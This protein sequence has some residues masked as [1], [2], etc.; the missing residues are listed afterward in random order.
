MTVPI[1]VRDVTYSTDALRGRIDDLTIALNHAMSAVVSS[2]S[3]ATDGPGR[4]VAAERTRTLTAEL[5]RIRHALVSVW[6]TVHTGEAGRAH[7][8]GDAVQLIAPYVMS[9]PLGVGYAV[10]T[11]HLWHALRPLADHSIDIMSGGNP[12]H[13]PVT[14][15]AL[16]AQSTSPPRSLQDRVDRIP[17]GDTHIRIERYAE[18]GSSRFEVY[19]SGT[20]FGGAHSDPWNA[21][22]NLDLV[23]TGS[24]PSLEAVKIAMTSAGITTQT[25]VVVTGHSQGGLLALAIGAAHQ[26]DVRAIITVGTPVGAVADVTD[27]PTVHV[28]HPEDPVPAFG[29]LIDP[30]SSTWIVPTPH[31]ERLMEAHHRT[32]Y[33]PSAAEIDNL[34]DPR[35]DEIR[36]NNQATGVGV[37][38][39]YRAVV[40]GGPHRGTGAE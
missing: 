14:V 38:R 22:S 32:T 17:A 4:I 23:E 15:T 26:F 5:D 18:D 10:W 25:P 1:P 31:G 8:L 34:H 39:D 6:M 28:V 21:Q 2:G 35:I 27:I 7:T 37:R 12:R 29:G 11:G 40:T 9:G 13:S 16:P 20:N 3:W 36:A 24:S 30:K 19:L 33:S